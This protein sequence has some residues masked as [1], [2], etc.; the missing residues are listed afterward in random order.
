VAVAPSPGEIYERA[1]QEGERR[2]SASWLET[3][4]T[5]FIAGFTIVY[6]MVALGITHALVAPAAG[7]GIGKLA[8]ALTFGL[9]LV[10][11][12]V[13]RAELFTENFLDPIAATLERRRGSTWGRVGR[14]WG[15]TLAFNLLRGASLTL[16]MTFADVLPPGTS[17]ALVGIAR[18]IHERGAASAFANAVAAGALLTL[19]T[20]LLQAADSIGSQ[21]VIAYLVGFFLALGPFN[22]VVVTALHLVFGMRYGAAIGWGDA[23]GNVAISVVG[24]LVGGLVF[25]TL[26]QTARAQERRA[27]G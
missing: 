4:S 7:E 14:F 3:A 27:D 22:H 21:M 18:E 26:T 25:V 6:G 13:G 24:N 2:L 5:G 10:F 9:G 12:V 20:Y 8:G 15:W 1:A 17:A 23:A 11:T 19:M 16:L